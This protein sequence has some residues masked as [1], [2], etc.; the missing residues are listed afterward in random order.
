MSK[1]T[2]ILCASLCLCAICLNSACSSDEKGNDNKTNSG[3][4]NQ[5]QTLDTNGDEQNSEFTPSDEVITLPSYDNEANSYINPLTGLKSTKDIAEKRPVAIMINN[6]KE[7]LPQEGISNADIVYEILEE[8]GITRLMCI[9]NDYKDIP[10]IGSIRS[11]RDYFIDISDIHDSILVHVGGS[12]YAKNVIESRKTHNID[13]IIY[14]DIYFERDEERLETMSLEH[15]MVITGKKLDK[16]I[17]EIGYRNSAITK[18]PLNFA[19]EEVPIEGKTARKISFPFSIG[20]TNN[21][22]AVS[23][24]NYDEQSG[25]YLKGHFGTAHV[26]G[27]N[28]RQ[29]A[30]KNVITLTV[31]MRP[32]PGDELGCLKMNFTGIGTG[33]YSC[34]GVMKDIVWTR[35][36][37]TSSYVLYENDG[38][39]PL[40]L[41]PGK[42]YIAIVPLGTKITAE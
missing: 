9:Y 10:K 34:G 17:S 2:K 21:P 3:K 24:F 13:G 25:N 32:I 31:D 4:T 28:N 33:T 29:L 39:T 30:F 41:N 19:S 15:T 26:D 12:T 23:F 42:S 8:G 14:E 22:Y 1:L 36:S 18:Q 16:A 7:S 38:V 20:R 40:T 6:L 5:E 37:K 35:D 11:T 27:A